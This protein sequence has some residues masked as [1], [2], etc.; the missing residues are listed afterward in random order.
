MQKPISNEEL[1]RTI[2][3]YRE[4]DNNAS[5]AAKALGIPR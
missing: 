4:A 1:T 5:A 2:E 3:A